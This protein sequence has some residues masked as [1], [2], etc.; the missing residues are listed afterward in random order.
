MSIKKLTKYPNLFNIN[1]ETKFKSYLTSK[2]I[3]ASNIAPN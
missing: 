2:E 3:F 1:A